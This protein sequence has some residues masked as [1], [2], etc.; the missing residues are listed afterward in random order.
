MSRIS[1]K[2][3]RSPLATVLCCTLCAPIPMGYAQQAPGP[4][5]QAAAKSTE[6][7]DYKSTQLQGDERILHALNRFTFGPRPDDLETVRAVGL[8]NWFDQ[9]LHPASI[10]QADLNARLAQF[11]AMQWTTAQLLYYL[12]GNAIIRQTMTGKAPVPESGYPHAI[13]ENQIDRNQTE[14]RSAGKQERASPSDQS[15]AEQ[16]TSLRR[17][18]DERR[19]A[20]HGPRLWQEPQHS[21][22][23]PGFCTALHEPI[24]TN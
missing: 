5:N 8:D 11:P 2:S 4:R 18:H 23:G 1:M 15:A 20:H 22:H 24:S 7:I 12:P 14:K 16:A 3:L 21:I 9:Q 19:S 17:H 10:D 13:Y 6:R